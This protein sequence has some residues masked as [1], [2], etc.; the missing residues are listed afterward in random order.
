MTMML[1]A[2]EAASRAESPDATRPCSGQTYWALVDRSDEA[3]L[4]FSTETLEHDLDHARKL[5]AEHP[6]TYRNQLAI[7]RFLDGWIARIVHDA[8]PCRF[9]EGFIQAL[10]EMSGHLRDGDFAVELGDEHQPRRVS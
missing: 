9:N 8:Q 2:N 5:L 7:A 4:D 1:T 6:E 10:V 3:L